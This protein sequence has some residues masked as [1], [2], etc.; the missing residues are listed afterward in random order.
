[1]PKPA[2][3]LNP[4]IFAVS[5]D[6]S[7]FVIYN[8]NQYWA[9]D[10]TTGKSLWNLTLNYQVN[11]NEE[12]PLYGVDD[13]LVWQPTDAAWMCYSIKT[14]ALLWET[15]SV[16]NSPWASTWTV[17]SAETNDLNNLY[18]ACPDGAMRAYSLKDGHLLWTSKAFAST[19]YANN[20]V[21][22]VIANLVMVDG[23]LYGY[24][25]YSTGYQLDP[26][27]RFAMTVCINA[28]TGDNIF[29]LNGGIAP[30]AAANGY[31]I[32]AS[33]YDGNMYC[34]GKG[35]TS[36]TVSAPDISIGLGTTAL[37]QGSVMDTSP[38]SSSATLTAMFAKGVPAISDADMSVWMDYLHM[39]NSTL[40]NAPP[41]CK[42]VPITLTA[43]DPNGNTITIGTAI[44][45]SKGTY[46]L[47]WTPTTPGL[48][49]IYAN[50]AG[51]DSYFS[52]SSA[53]YA[54]VASASASSPAPN[55]NTQP[56]VSNSDM[57]MY[58]VTTGIVIVI[59]IA[60]ATV[61]ILRKK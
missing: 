35:P 21:P 53:T 36:T 37:I 23:K 44:S 33:I 19:E 15:P 1:M 50:F 49:T 11:T 34:L 38:A 30:S 20:A 2:S 31:V 48:Y 17:Y 22:F 59:A 60:I 28:T 32:G 47:Q 14:G 26:V 6:M 51:S 46:G 9:Y 18:T 39:Q 41:N 7:V 40:L 10:A 16:A 57:L 25:G 61:L 12:V 3:Y 52:S 43:V 13:F 8:R 54:T 45:N 24:A 27:P 5:N 58:V 29:A 56:V 42:G 55:S 4:S